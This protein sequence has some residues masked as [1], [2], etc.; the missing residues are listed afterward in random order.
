MPYDW[1]DKPHK[2]FIY[3]MATGVSLLVSSILKVF[4]LKSNN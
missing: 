2:M 4:N 1:S 3:Y